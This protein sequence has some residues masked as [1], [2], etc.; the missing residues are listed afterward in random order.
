MRVQP[1]DPRLAYAGTR[2]VIGREG[3]PCHADDTPGCPRQDQ[4]VV[5]WAT[6]DGQ[7]HVLDGAQRLRYAGEMERWTPAVVV[8][9][10][11]AAVEEMNEYGAGCPHG[12]GCPEHATPMT[13][14]DRVVRVALLLDLDRPAAEQ[15]RKEGQLRGVEARKTGKSLATKTPSEISRF[16]VALKGLWGARQNTLN[17]LTYIARRWRY[18]DDAE[19]AYIRAA[20][21]RVDAGL[22]GLSGLVE[23]LSPVHRRYWRSPQVTDPAQLAT[24]LSGLT[25]SATSMVSVLD[26]ISTEA[27]RTLP[28]FDAAVTALR[29]L[30]SALHTTTLTRQ[31]KK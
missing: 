17:H 22:L 4:P 19:R 6:D 27:A 30:H 18:G 15:A 29:A 14:L 12:A 13:T 9:D 8:R 2:V 16:E 1:D 3:G 20:C 10:V 11:R 21:G 7:L 23:T 5:L 28:S 31:E 25:A 26:Q 24:M